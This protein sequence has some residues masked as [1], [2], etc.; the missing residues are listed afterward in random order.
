V[1][2]LREGGSL[3]AIVDADDGFPYV[4][5]FRGAGQ[6]KKALI[7][8]V[9][10]GELA[11]SLGLKM[12]ELVFLHLDD[13]FSKTE[14]DEEIQDLLRFSVGLN[15]G[16]HFLSGAM[17]FDPVVSTIDALTAS[18]VVLL[19]SLITNID[20]TPKNPNLLMWNREL[21]LI[22]HGASL[23]FHHAWDRWEGPEHKPF[24]AIADHILLRQA[25]RLEDAADHI[26]KVTQPS[27]I[28]T[29]LAQIPDEWLL[30]ETDS[31][32]PDQKRTAYRE[33][34]SSRIVN[35]QLLTQEADDARQAG[36]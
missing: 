10:G 35:I 6:G 9:I 16:L 24:P 13:T 8:E 15:V 22:D 34:L 25:T 33:F 12:P 11:R 29:I 5:K 18:L 20:R 3:P 21:W 19:D 14:P 7:A 30:E 36:V 23:Y 17:T 2:P 28:E 1:T 32:T 4:I 27:V 26:V 31:W